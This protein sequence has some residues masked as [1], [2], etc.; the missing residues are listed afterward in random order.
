LRSLAPLAP[1]LAEL[2]PDDVLAGPAACNLA[3]LWGRG[4]QLY[5]SPH[6]AHRSLIPDREVHE[7]HA[8]NA[9]LQGRDEADYAAHALDEGSFSMTRSPRPEWQSEAVRE[10]RLT[11]FRALLRGERPDLLERYRPTALLL[12]GGVTPVRGGPWELAAQ[13]PDWSLWRKRQ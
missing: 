11:L 12:P 9:W 7:R 4:G 3:V 13:S 10:V 8:L 1:A 2:G 5:Q 6:T